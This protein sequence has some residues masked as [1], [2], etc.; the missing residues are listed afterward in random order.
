ITPKWTVEYAAG[1][2]WTDNGKSY[3]ELNVSYKASDPQNPLDVEFSMGINVGHVGESES[4]NTELPRISFISRNQ[5]MLWIPNH[6]LKAKGLGII[7]HTS[8]YFPDIETTTEFFIREDQTVEL[9]GNSLINVPATDKTPA[10]HRAAVS[11]SLGVPPAKDKPSLIKRLSHKLAVKSLIRRKEEPLE[12]QISKLPLHEFK[13]RGWDATTEQWRMP[14]YP[15]LD[16]TLAQTPENSETH[17]WDLEVGDLS[18]DKL[19]KFK[20]KQRE[21]GPTDLGG[22]NGKIATDSELTEGEFKAEEPGVNNPQKLKGKQRNLGMEPGTE[23]GILIKVDN[24][25]EAGEGT[26][27]MDPGTPSFISQATSTE[28]GSLATPGSASHSTSFTTTDT[29]ALGGVLANDSQAGP[30]KTGDIA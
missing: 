14:V 12:P 30:S 29:H 11:F 18:T 21:P 6:S 1:D 16:S 4:S 17:V 19:P 27:H 8:A 25:E 13:A 5:T 9:S 10:N 26:S 7:A 28:S 3:E 24:A 2:D 15:R 22:D 20:G 23:S